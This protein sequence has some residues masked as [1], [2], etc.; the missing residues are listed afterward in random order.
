MKN[1]NQGLCLKLIGDGDIPQILL[2]SINR[3]QAYGGNVNNLQLQFSD[4]ITVPITEEKNIQYTLAGYIL[5]KGNT[6]EGHYRVIIRG[7]K[8]CWFLYNDAEVKELTAFKRNN[9]YYTSEV[10][11]LLYA[12]T[13]YYEQ[14]SYYNEQ[15]YNG[16]I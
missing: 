13:A 15:E 2:L 11:L 7:K 4:T 8:N 16:A 9:H 6:D 10:I 5:F 3:Y 12:E 14:E 1:I